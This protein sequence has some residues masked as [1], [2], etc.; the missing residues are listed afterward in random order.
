MCGEYYGKYVRDT[1]VNVFGDTDVN[2]WGILWGILW[3]VH[4]GYC[5]ICAMN[6]VVYVWKVLWEILGRYY[7]KC[8]VYVVVN[9]W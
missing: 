3:V 9:V 8:V 6:T 1:V 7:G 4:G 5:G 2:M